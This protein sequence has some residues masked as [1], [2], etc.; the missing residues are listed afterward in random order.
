MFELV[1]SKGVLYYKSNILKSKHAFS[2]RIGGK[3]ELEHTKSLNIAFGHG[4]DEKT[5]LENLGLLANALQIDAKRIISVPQVHSNEVRLVSAEEA[6]QGTFNKAAFSCDGYITLE[7]DLP[8]GVK[9]AD[10]VPILLEGRN[11]AGEIVAVSA[12]HAGWRG[13]AAKIAVEAI[14]KLCD[15]G[16]REDN[17]YAAI[18]PCIDVCCYEVGIDFANQIAKK[19]GQNYEI[20]HIKTNGDGTRYADLK[21]MNL[22]ILIS[23]GVPKNNIDVSPLCTCCNPDLFYSHRRQ[24]GIRGAHINVISKQR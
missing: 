4:D 18:G 14:K 7:N 9:T 22:D 8:L 23:C 2:T 13:T 21:S 20:K 5:V 24:K 12:V 15:F 11:D 17:I 10:C 6:G 3:S 19:L 16:V 1:E